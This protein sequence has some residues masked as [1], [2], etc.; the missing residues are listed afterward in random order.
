MNDETQIAIGHIKCWPEAYEMGTH[1][2]RVCALIVD[3]LEQARNRECKAFHAGMTAG[4][5]GFG[6]PE[7][8][9][10]Q[11]WQQYAGESE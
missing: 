9:P 7:F 2:T 11:A 3:A 10:A 1:D 8:D 6:R 4:V 5:E